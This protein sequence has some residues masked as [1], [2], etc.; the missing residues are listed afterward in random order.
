MKRL[1]LSEETKNPNL[2][3]SRRI[4]GISDVRS[5]QKILLFQL[6]ECR[7]STKRALSGFPF[8]CLSFTA[9]LKFVL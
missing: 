3:F 2:R 9:D 7:Y 8:I 5:Y 4:V 1:F 6:E